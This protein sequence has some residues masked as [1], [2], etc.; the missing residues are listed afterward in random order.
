[1]IRTPILTV[2][3]FSFLGYWRQSPALYRKLVVGLLVFTLFN[4]S[5]IFLLLQAKQAGLNDT[6]II[7]I[8]IFYNLVFVLFA[9]PL[10]I[11]ADKIGM[12]IILTAGV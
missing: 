1:M 7:T 8:Y 11:L 4:S 3:F 5:D 12:K 10:G 2:S 9:F 6:N